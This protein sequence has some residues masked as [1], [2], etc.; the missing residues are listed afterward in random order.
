MITEF[1]K[2]SAQEALQVLDSDAQN[3]LAGFQAAKRLEQDGPNRLQSAKKKSLMLRILEQFKDF[4]VVIL[5]AAAIVSTIAGDGLKDAIIII[6][7]LVFN[8]IIG[9]T[10][11]NKADNALKALKDM[12]SPKAKVKRD[13]AID[14][15]DSDHVVKGDIV[16]L[17]AGDYIPADVRIIES[18]N[19]KVDESALTGESV[20]ALKDCNVIFE[21]EVTLGDRINLAAMGTVVSY[22]RGVG[23]VYATGAQTEM[24]KIAT[25]LQE[26]NEGSTPLQDKLNALAKTLGIVCIITCAI[27]FLVG[28]LYN[29][30]GIGSYR[31]LIDMMMVSVSLAVAAVPEGIAIVATVILAIGVQKMVRSNAIVKKLRAVETLGSTTVICSDKTGTLTQNKMTVVKCFDYENLYEVTGVGYDPVGEVTGAVAATKNIA[32]MSE[33]A[34]L[35]NDAIYD[36]VHS[37]IIGD[38]TEGAMLVFGAKLGNDK[39]ECSALHK[40]VQEIPFDSERKLMSTFNLKDGKVI[41]N[42]KGAPDAIIERATKIYADGKIVPMDG[43][44]KARLLAQNEQFAADA[45][46]V[47]GFA[48]KE[49]DSEA[50]IDNVEE[51]LI[52]VGTM[53]MIDPP[54]KEVKD[55]VAQC[56]GAGI[57]VK[58]ITGDHKITAAAIAQSLGIMQ[59]EGAV[60]D[61]P[62]INNLS[63]AELISKVSTV[64]VY[65]RVSPEHKVRIVTAIKANNH[66]VAMTGDGVNDAPALKKADIGIAMG[67]TGTDVSKEAADMILT[68]DNFV[69]IVDA[70]SQ[71]RTIYGNIRKVTG[72]LLANNIGEILIIL[73]AIIFGLPVP[74]VA[75]QLLFVNLLTD[76]FPAFALG[77]EGKEKNVMRKKPRDPLEPIVNKEMG[78]SVAF[79]SAFVA[80]ASLASF[81]IGHFAIGDYLV[82]ISM[83]FFTLVASE[84]LVAYPSKKETFLGFKKTMFDNRFL[85]LSTLA[86]MV[87]LFAVMYIPILN[88]LFTTVPL[89]VVQLGIALGL[90]ILPLF[91]F[92][93]SKKFDSIPD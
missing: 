80:G 88:D 38:P 34:V 54:R 93:I 57:T 77:M 71:G 87:I 65:A 49:Y 31:D 73:L 29:I 4:L 79:R 86:A 64:D 7:I 50:A 30:L 23:V 90:V 85:N 6:A 15:I 48:Y 32:L 24:G 70:V 47:L 40:R 58:M 62:A 67:I 2:I 42:T 39:N 60:L 53:C 76:A 83:C 21:D 35:C 66:I 74:L 81:L 52:Y 78:V 61:G 56:H 11:E 41:M 63:D 28:F 16:I 89:S 46:R 25:I 3:G 22:G 9:I 27:V 68:D 10:Q 91:G 84:L 37:K 59:P 20:P 26:T 43:D 18:M 69:S 72:Y 75:T 55:S 45:L 17:D 82:A 51:A 1:Y 33:I 12:S 5:I 14:K 92:E 36:K 8:M 19:L 13:G 44:K